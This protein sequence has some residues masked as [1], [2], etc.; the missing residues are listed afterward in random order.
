MSLFAIIGLCGMYRSIKMA[1]RVSINDIT[2][3]FLSVL[4]N[5]DV[6]TKI[7][8]VLAASIKLFLTKQIKPVHKKLDKIMDENKSLL[9]GC[10][11]WI[12]KITK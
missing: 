8:Q 1:K 2:A 4:D 6:I 9:P 5:E 12:K 11:T 10:Q 3:S 7:G